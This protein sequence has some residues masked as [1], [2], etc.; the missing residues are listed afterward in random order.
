MSPR[1]VILRALLDEGVP[2]SVAEVL[3]A[4]G[5]HVILHREVLLSG[6]QDDVVGDAALRHNAIL[7]GNDGDMKQMTKRYGAPSSPRFANLSIIR[8][9]CNETLAAKRLEQ[10]LSLIIHEW[11]FTSEK[12]SRRLWIDI[13]EHDIRTHR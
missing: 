12:P 9:C 13:R 5:H 7:I 1:R 10:A 3:R 11:D 8:L 4:N 6:A 2:D